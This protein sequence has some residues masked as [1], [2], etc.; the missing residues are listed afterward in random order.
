M[1]MK[2]TLTGICI[3]I[4]LLSFK[5]DNGGLSKEN[6]T[7]SVIATYSDA[8]R[9]LNQADAGCEI[10]A[11]NEADFKS[12]QF[13]DLK[14]VIERFQGYKYD[15]LLSIYN[16]VDPARID[17]LRENFDTLADI[18]AKYISEFRKL[19]VLVKAVTNAE[20]HAALSLRPGKYYIL[21]VSGTVKSNNSAESKGN[22]GYKIVEIKSSLETIQK[23]CF[24]KQDM[25]GIMMARNLSGC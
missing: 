11:I 8:Y 24:Q 7:L 21:F 18:T 13:N 3:L 10:Y 20:G 25:T 17:K 5:I 14:G 19:P 23:V 9:S 4:V 12:T 6:G 15:Y 2:K 16:S 1:I 22:V